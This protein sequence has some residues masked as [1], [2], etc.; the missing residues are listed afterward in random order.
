MPDQGDIPEPGDIPDHGD[1]PDHGDIPD[2]GDMPDIIG[3]AVMPRLKEFNPPRPL[4]KLLPR[5][6]LLPSIAP[7]M[8][9]IMVSIIRNIRPNMLSAPSAA[10]AGS[11][12][13]RANIKTAIAHFCFINCCSGCALP[14]ILGKKA[15]LPKRA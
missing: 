1:M 2:Q 7:D 6:L 15:L 3:K 8:T 11:G 12:A 14:L 10:A 4:P 9:F 13:A 5:L